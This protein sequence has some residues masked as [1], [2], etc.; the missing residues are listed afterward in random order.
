MT[1]LDEDMSECCSSEISCFI[2][3]VSLYLK[4]IVLKHN[5]FSSL[6]S[7]YKLMKFNDWRGR[8]IRLSRDGRTAT[9]TETYNHGLTMT[10]DILL[11]NTLFQVHNKFKL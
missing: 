2:D 5:K 9:R 3:E 6:Q 11:P 8:N 10:S 4:K 1:V 7:T